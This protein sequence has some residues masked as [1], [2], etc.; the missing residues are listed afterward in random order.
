MP[1]LQ[2]RQPGSSLPGAVRDAAMR[3]GRR[4]SPVDPRLLEQVR[5]ALARLPDRGKNHPYVEIPGD[6][7]A[8]PREPREAQ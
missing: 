8:S 4:R 5:N 7:L 3:A 1:E 6:C 2:L